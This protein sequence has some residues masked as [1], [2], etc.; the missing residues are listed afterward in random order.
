MTTNS[1]KIYGPR[2]GSTL[3]THW[4]AAEV[5]TVYETVA[6]DFGKGENR[7]ESFL[8]I[9]A[10]GQVPALVDGDFRL[11]E[12]M[13]ICSYL[14]DLAGSDLAG[15]TPQERA[16]AWQWSLWAALN[17]YRHMS[18]LA[19]PAWTQQA[20]PPEE[21]AAAKAALAKYLPILEA[22]LARRPFIAGSNFTTGDIN[23]A[24]ILGYA[25]FSGYD[26]TPSPAI[27]SWLAKVTARPAY[28][29]AKGA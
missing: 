9:N 10:M 20:L 19:S 12:S 18:A 21:E 4:V 7:S 11:A 13:A 23:V 5:G 6:V 24:T 8:K 15:K 25:A 2:M 28:A 22:H 27:T 16:T 29:Q 17:L 14:V 3:R 26:L 1:I